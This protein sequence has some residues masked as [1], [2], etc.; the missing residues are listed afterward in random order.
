M[1]SGITTAFDPNLQFE[2]A[3]PLIADAGF[4][5]ISLSWEPCHINYST[6]DDQNK[7]LQI[8]EKNDLLIESIHAPWRTD[9]G[10]FDEKW[11]RREINSVLPSIIAAGNMGIEYIV[12]HAG[13]GDENTNLHRKK[14]DATI[15]SIEELSECAIRNNV[16]LAV[17]NLQ[18]KPSRLLT[19]RI[20]KEFPQD[21]IGFCHDT[22]HEHCSLDCFKA[23]ESMGSRLFCTHVHD[24]TGHGKD[25]HLLPYSG[26]IDWD[27]YVSIMSKLNYSGHL[28]I[29]SI[30]NRDDGFK[31]SRE[32]LKEAK[33]RVDK[34][35]SAIKRNN[36]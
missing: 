10:V 36:K 1:L 25:D 30:R 13:W 16:K 14:I 31:N 6:E 27:L 15:K 24:D 5:V 21:H 29:E 20:L 8:A 18:G 35:I 17:E 34:L 19:E 33:I 22:G 23:L 7:I 11:R 9:F 28:L 4:E 32:F 26:T 2:A 3:V 12:I